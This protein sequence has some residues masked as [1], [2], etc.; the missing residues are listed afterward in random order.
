MHADNFGE[1]T[2]QLNLSSVEVRVL[3]RQLTKVRS[4]SGPEN[5]EREQF[6]DEAYAI[7]ADPRIPQEWF[8]GEPGAC[9][10]ANSGID[11]KTRGILSGILPS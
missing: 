3:H 8:V 10:R 4:V 9:M 6:R 7:V 11:P 1:I 5:T 2:K